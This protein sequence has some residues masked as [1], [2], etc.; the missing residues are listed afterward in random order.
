M[1][2]GLIQLVSS[3]KQDGY[4]SYNPEIT[5][6][7]KVYRRHTIFGIEFIVNLP[8]QQPAYDNRV[9]FILNNISDLISKCYIQI[10]IPQLSFVENSIIT[11]LKQT[12]L[13]NYQKDINKWSTLYNNLKEYCSI[14][15]LLYQ[16]LNNLL[17][18]INITLQLLK[19]NVI[20]FN[21]KYKK[22]KDALTNLIA[23]DIFIKIDLTG[24]ILQLKLMIVS[25]DY[26]N[27]NPLTEI[28][29]STLITNINNYYN[30]MIQ[31]LNYYY[32]NYVFSSNNY[33]NL[34]NKSVPFAWVEYLAHAYFTE[35]ELEI[36]GQVVEQYS[37]EQSFIYQQHHIK[38]ELRET[39]NKMI[40]QIENLYTF[41]NNTK[42]ATTL[43]LPL[44]FWFCKDIGSALPTV[45]MANTSIAVNLKLNTLKNL[46][47]FQ[48]WEADYY[49][50]LIVTTYKD[51]TI[52]SNLNYISFTYD[53]KST[54]I[55]YNCSNINY[56]LFALKYPSLSSPDKNDF[57]TTT[58]QTYGILVNGK[59][60]MTLK[61]WIRFKTLNTQNLDIL[62]PGRNNNFNQF[63][64]LIPPPSLS[65]I[66]ESIYLDDLERNK[67]ASTKLEYVV[68]IFQENIYNIEKQLIFNAELSISS[69]IKELIWVT[70][71]LVL[72]QGLSEYGKKYNT[73]FVFNDFFKNFYYTNYQI[74]LNQLQVVKPK[75]NNIFF[76][77][78]Q[79][80]KYY[81]NQ[82]PEGVFAYNFGLY[83]EEI[84]PSGT[85]NFSMLKGKLLNFTLDNN[86]LTEYFDKIFNP[87]QLGLQLKFMARSYNFFVVEK[88]QARMIF[89]SS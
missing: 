10:N 9:S 27:F 85:C 56:Q 6:F 48:D 76:N 26:E 22:Q 62:D 43:I 18:S 2:G 28:K 12:Q 69:P 29:I 35:I 89:A 21:A 20:K 44:N 42:N 57:I 52:N 80:W 11:K 31:N 14:E 82:L 75:L 40:G 7:R 8:D 32:T 87:S 41:N 65:L 16:N 70:Q 84:Q 61:E 4:L 54:L 33:T 51:N 53:E 38:E 45:A 1:T 77:Q 64:S 37:L 68:E 39:Y 67:F 83:P 60:V 79:S 55:T 3:G 30:N 24:Y 63:Y 71:P 49:N 13:A 34:N 86:F 66:T 46:L 15:M 50:F 36:G 88:G 47:Y 72:L 17:K 58:L 59:Y 73:R 74:S 5:F 23:D 25:D 81:N 19:Q 78:L